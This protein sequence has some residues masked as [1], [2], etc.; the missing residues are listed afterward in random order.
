MEDKSARNGPQEDIVP[1]AMDRSS[2]KSVGHSSG[3]LEKQAP[4]Q[5]GELQ[6][7]LT[8]RHL[9]F[10]AIGRSPFITSL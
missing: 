8:S 6:R 3:D 4:A 1:V 5:N 2:E 9:Q 10:V 7:K